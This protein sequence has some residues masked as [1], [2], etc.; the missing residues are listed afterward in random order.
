[1]EYNDLVG[2]TGVALIL[3][4]Y[5]L[6]TCN[7]IKQ[8]KLFIYEYFC[9]PRWPVMLRLK[10]NY[11]RSYPGRCLAFGVFVRVNENNENKNVSRQRG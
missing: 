1:M 11:R 7:Y 9:V 8:G 2:C 3:F 5:F 6:N 4:A 10:S